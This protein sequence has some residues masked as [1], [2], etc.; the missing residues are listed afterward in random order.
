MRKLFGDF[1]GFGLL[2]VLLVGES[3]VYLYEDIDY[4]NTNK[5]KWEEKKY[6]TKYL[7]TI[8]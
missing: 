2:C 6:L 1:V 7:P 5:T 8:K 3:V 4:L